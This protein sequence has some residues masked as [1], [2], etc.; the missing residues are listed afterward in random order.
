MAVMAET[1]SA[2]YFDASMKARAERVAMMYVIRDKGTCHCLRLPGCLPLPGTVALTLPLPLPQSAWYCLGGAA[3][4]GTVPGGPRVS[5]FK[6][7]GLE[8]GAQKSFVVTGGE[9]ERE[10]MERSKLDGVVV[11]HEDGVVHAFPGGSPDDN[12]EH[13]IHHFPRPAHPDLCPCHLPNHHQA[14]CT[15]RPTQARRDFRRNVDD[16]LG[17]GGRGCLERGS[18]GCG[19]DDGVFD[20]MHPRRMDARRRS[21]RAGGVDGCG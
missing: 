1:V 2:A 10:A 18:G 17:L 8:G 21:R 4:S 7:K 15:S 6:S 12:R 13:P 11:E 20:Q 14:S 19:W 5:L 16:H 9:G 3:A